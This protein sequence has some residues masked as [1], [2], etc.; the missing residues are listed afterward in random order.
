MNNIIITVVPSLDRRGYS[1]SHNQPE[2]FKGII[3]TQWAWFKN[4]LDA[5]KS[6]EEL[7]KTW[8]IKKN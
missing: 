5:V 7:M 4:R 1:L 8:N 6:A 2:G 3:G